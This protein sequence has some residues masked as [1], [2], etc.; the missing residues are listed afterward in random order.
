MSY[1]HTLAVLSL[2]KHIIKQPAATNFRATGCSVCVTLD[3]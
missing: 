2:K 3:R 1:A